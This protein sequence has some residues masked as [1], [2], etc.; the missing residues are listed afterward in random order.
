MRIDRSRES[1]AVSYA[2]GGWTKKILVRNGAIVNGQMYWPPFNS[3][4]YHLKGTTNSNPTLYNRAAPN[5]GPRTPNDLIYDALL[6]HGRHNN[7]GT[8]VV[9]CTVE[10]LTPG[11]TYEIQIFY[12]NKGRPTRITEWD[13]G[14]G[15]REGQGG[16]F[17]RPVGPNFGQV[18]TGTFVATASGKQTFSNYQQPANTTTTPPLKETFNACS[19]F[20]VRDLTPKALAP[21]A[22]YYGEGTP[23]TNTQP[24]LG[25]SKCSPAINLTGHPVMNSTV[26][27]TAEN[28]SDVATSAL[29][30][31]GVAPAVIPFL[32][33]QLLV[34]PLLTLPVAMPQPATPYVH[35]HELQLPVV[36]PAS[37]IPVYVQV[38]Q[39]DNGAK[40]GVS[41][42]PGLK[43]EVGT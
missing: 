7:G 28:S 27:L 19:A 4:G 33:G 29:L 12:G 34:A 14:I 13:N 30:V 6:R 43:I 40:E 8:K 1:E 22:T 35:T 2:T 39:L 17:L 41:F 15:G 21:R 31:L 23:G 37:S 16:I 9:T 26:M 3:G 18:A 36:L 24:L 10:G 25:G 38:L 20:Q 5:I 11:N 32:S 42:T